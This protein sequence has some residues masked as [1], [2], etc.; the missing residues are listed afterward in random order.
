MAS[1]CGTLGKLPP[2]VR[3][4]IFITL[5]QR[6][7]A[8]LYRS[9]SED[10]T[11]PPKLLTCVVAILKTCRQVYGEG[12]RVLALSLQMVV[13]SFE[14]TETEVGLPESFYPLSLKTSFYIEQVRTLTM[15]DSD[16]DGLLIWGTF[17]KLQ[18]LY[19]V[20]NYLEEE[21]K[22][23]GMLHHEGKTTTGRKVYDWSFG[24]RDSEYVKKAITK[25]R[26]EPRFH[27]LRWELMDILDKVNVYRSL[28][29]FVEI[30]C[31]HSYQ[32][33]IVSF[34][35]TQVWLDIDAVA[36]IDLQYRYRR[37]RGASS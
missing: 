8:V 15:A 26:A 25:F 19:L 13:S 30:D 17:P 21:E 28:R 34:S 9:R 16:V 36:E 31:V 22:E 27:G 5:F 35:V 20:S 23:Y 33:M 32:S 18:S 37:N 10:Y 2:E 6:P 1:T 29:V 7:R 3:D 11:R 14:E 12:R 4:K 24:S